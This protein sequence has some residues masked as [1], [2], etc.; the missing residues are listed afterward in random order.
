[1]KRLRALLTCLMYYLHLSKP[2]QL[3]CKIS[4]RISDI[5]RLEANVAYFIADAETW[6]AQ[7]A[8]N[9]DPNGL[10]VL[11][12]NLE[13]LQ[14][15]LFRLE[16]QLPV[17]VF[18]TQRFLLS[19]TVESLQKIQSNLDTYLGPTAAHSMDPEWE[20]GPSGYPRRV[21]D[22]DILREMFDVG[23][24]DAEVAGYFGVTRPT[25]AARR[26]SI[27]LLKVNK[28][29]EMSDEELMGVSKANENRHLH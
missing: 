24:S 17:P 6:M 8:R 12:G 27:G 18:E 10:P 11:I 29:F 22:E 13:R 14:E 3:N 7:D 19:H 25:I 21:I 26:T 4:L 2:I 20:I 16:L 23:I 1:M 28:S 5:E 9:R 15:D